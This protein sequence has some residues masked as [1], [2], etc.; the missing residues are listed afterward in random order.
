PRAAG[1][2][3]WIPGKHVLVSFRSASANTHRPVRHNGGAAA[4]VSPVARAGETSPGP[5][6]LRSGEVIRDFP[7]ITS[8][9]FP[10]TIAKPGESPHVVG[11]CDKWNKSKRDPVSWASMRWISRRLPG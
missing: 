2:S 5:R 8:R 10:V 1:N 11:V 9:H 7:E 3:L 4:D 6:S